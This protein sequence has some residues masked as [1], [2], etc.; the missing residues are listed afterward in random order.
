[1]NFQSLPSKSIH[2]GVQYIAKFNNGYGASVVRHSFSYGN[3]QGFWELA[4]LDSDG[5]ITYDT[6]ITDDVL[7]YLTEEDV[8]NTLN[9]IKTLPA[10]ILCNEN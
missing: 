5:D 10:K 1:M 4:V 6:P 3:Q 2:G 8:E 7:G 9:K